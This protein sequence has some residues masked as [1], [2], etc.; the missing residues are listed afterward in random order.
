MYF[1]WTFWGE[2]HKCKFIL[3]FV[4]LVH[5][6]YKA[7][8]DSRSAVDI[9]S[10]FYVCSSVVVVQVC[11]NNIIIVYATMLQSIL[12]LIFTKWLN[13]EV[14]QLLICLLYSK[15]TCRH[16]ILVC[17]LLYILLLLQ[18]TYSSIYT[19]TSHVMLTQPYKP[20]QQNRI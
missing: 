6:V 2:N 9:L 1:I 16:A 14:V 13:K 15:N 11:I 18:D 4:L 20:L 7:K 3:F 5:Y 8:K 17:M 12:Q 10:F 19:S